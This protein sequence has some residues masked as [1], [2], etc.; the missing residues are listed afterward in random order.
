MRGVPTSSSSQMYQ[1]LVTGSCSTFTDMVRPPKLN[2][3]GAAPGHVL[4]RD[5]APEVPASNEL[6]GV[7]IVGLFMNRK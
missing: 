1:R 4:Y 2:N 5:A 7:F 6:T 3:P